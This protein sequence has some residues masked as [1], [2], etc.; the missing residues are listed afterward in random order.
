MP[1]GPCII[2]LM[3]ILYRSGYLCLSGSSAEIILSYCS[4]HVYLYFPVI[5]SKKCA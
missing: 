1:Q 4:G 2:C 3:T 5:I